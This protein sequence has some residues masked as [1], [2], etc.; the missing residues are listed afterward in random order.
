NHDRSLDWHL[1]EQG[2]HAGLQR[3][4]RD[5]NHLYRE[6]TALH[7]LDCAPEG[8]AWI[9]GGDAEQSV[10]SFERRDRDGNVVV[11]ISNMTPMVRHD[12]NLGLPA[13]GV[14]RE[15]LNTDATEYGGSG[16]GNGGHIGTSEIPM[17]GRAHSASLV[18]PPLATIVLAPERGES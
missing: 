15:I 14:W 13:G 2:E 10:F 12:Y 3:L 6:R 1:L 4:I 7:Q 11:A 18:L 17:H 9:E 8:F 5:L 16:V